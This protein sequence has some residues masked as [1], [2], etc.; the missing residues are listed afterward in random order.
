MW[1]VETGIGLCHRSTPQLGLW[2]A[3]PWIEV[4]PQLAHPT[5]CISL[6]CRHFI[7][8]FLLVSYPRVRPSYPSCPQIAITLPLAHCKTCRQALGQKMDMSPCFLTFKIA[9]GV[10]NNPIFG[11]REPPN[12]KIT[13]G[14]PKL[15]LVQFDIDPNFC[16]PPQKC[17]KS[18]SRYHIY[19]YVTKCLTYTLGVLIGSCFSI[20]MKGDLRPM[21][22]YIH[23]THCNCWIWVVNSSTNCSVDL[24][25]VEVVSYSVLAIV[26]NLEALW[27]LPPF[28]TNLRHVL[29]V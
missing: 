11:F 24:S 14:T 25:M 9:K 18:I 22:L 1:R 15:Y 23:P 12:F 16:G 13:I 21:F 28:K 7:C 4:S 26:P 2:P 10:C 5:D 6:H 19:S 17:H 29:D 20:S 27:L 8:A 3:R